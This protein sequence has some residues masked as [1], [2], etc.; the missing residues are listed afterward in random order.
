MRIKQKYNAIFYG[1]WVVGACLLITAYTAG[2]VHFG[3]TALFEPIAAEFGWSYAQVSFAASIRGVETGFLAPLIGLLV[4]RWGPRKLMAGGAIILGISL[5]FLSRVTSLGMFYGAFVLMA[6]A[7]SAC[8]QLVAITA[9]VDWFHKRVSVAIGIVI[10]GIGLGGLMVPVVVKL[11]DLFDWRTAILILAFGAWGIVLPLSLLVRRRVKQH[12]SPSDGETGDTVVV[13]EGRASAQSVDVHIGARQIL[14]SGSFWHIAVALTCHSLFV[15]AV[16]THVMPYLSSVNIARTTSGLVASA[17][18]LVS[19]GGRLSFG[20]FGDRIDK[21]WV[22]AGAFALM[23]SGLLL[24]SYTAIGGAWLLMPFLLLF[25]VGWGGSVI[26]RA[27]LVR[28]N[29]GRG[30]FGTTLGFIIAVAHLGAITG[31]PLAGWVFDKW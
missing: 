10:S 1:W 5:M 16:T 28:E 26:M 17:L 21:R 4:D 13:N 3:F 15:H 29:F 30:S 31:P 12:G 19:I 27:A 25:S 23:S 18:P 2:A 7:T 14:A 11:I 6:I 9:V 22:A 20:W 24:F 8:S